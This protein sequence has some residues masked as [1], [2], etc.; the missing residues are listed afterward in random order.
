MKKEGN[1]REE[2]HSG[3]I[4]YRPVAV[5]IKDTERFPKLFFAVCLSHLPRH[6]VD[7][8]LKVY[9]AVAYTEQPWME[10]LLIGLLD[11]HVLLE[12]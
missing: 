6:H 8:L 10:L 12:T 2:K 1:N 4:D 7:E 3:V 11:L 5:F 9:R